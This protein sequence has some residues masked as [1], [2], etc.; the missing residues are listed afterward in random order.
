[1]GFFEADD[2]SSIVNM[3]VALNF[4][5]PS[6]VDYY[7]R[8]VPL[9]VALKEMPNP[10]TNVIPDAANKAFNPLYE[11]IEDIMQALFPFR[12]KAYDEEAPSLKD[13][14]KASVEVSLD[15]AD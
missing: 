14:I 10:H 4:N 1:L 13:Y 6:V 2:A 3:M 9:W 11:V 15:W 5:K 8:K 12:G 7:Q